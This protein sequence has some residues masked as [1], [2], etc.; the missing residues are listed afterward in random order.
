MNEDTTDLT[1]VVDGGSETD[2]EE[3]SKLTTQVR[4]RLLELDVHTVELVRTGDLPEGAKPV[5]A[6]TIG[7]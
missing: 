2:A 4:Q 1:L 5:N 3:V 6:V 7:R